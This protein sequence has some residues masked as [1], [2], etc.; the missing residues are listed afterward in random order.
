MLFYFSFVEKRKLLFL[1]L[2]ADVTSRFDRVFW[3]GDFNFRINKKRAEADEV[4]AKRDFDDRE[5]R[6]TFII[7]VYKFASFIFSYFLH[8][9]IFIS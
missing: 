7:K 5:Q 3:F 4:F 1:F 9:H 8:F 2:S 6:K